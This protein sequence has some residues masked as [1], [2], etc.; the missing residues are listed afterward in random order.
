MGELGRENH[1]FELVKAERWL[2]KKKTKK[3]YLPGLCG[4]G[5]KKY[6]F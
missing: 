3:F 4:E 2:L 1:C 5:E 6:G